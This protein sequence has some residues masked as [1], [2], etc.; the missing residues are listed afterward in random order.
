MSIERY[1]CLIPAQRHDPSPQ[2]RD[3][4]AS[5]DSPPR[6]RDPRDRPE[7]LPHHDP[8]ARYNSPPRQPHHQADRRQPAQGLAQQGVLHKQQQQWKSQPAHQRQPPQISQMQAPSQKACSLQPAPWEEQQKRAEMMEYHKLQLVSCNR[9]A[10]QDQLRVEGIIET[11]TI[12]TGSTTTDCNSPSQVCCSTNTSSSSNLSSNSH[13]CGETQPLGRGRRNSFRKSRHW[14]P[15]SKTKTTWQAFPRSH[16][17]PTSLTQRLGGVLNL[18][19]TQTPQR[20]RR[21]D[22]SRSEQQPR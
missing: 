16:R 13:K 11:R 18:H 1:P 17:T 2:Q 14:Q 21:Q 10:T 7:S 12:R 3:P 19:T 20:E 6:Y 9:V 22:H 15:S 5:R 8:W 4:L